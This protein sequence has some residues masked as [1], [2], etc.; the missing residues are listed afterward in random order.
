MVGSLLTHSRAGNVIKTILMDKIGD[1]KPSSTLEES[2]RIKKNKQ[3][4]NGRQIN[5]LI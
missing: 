5:I 2:K 1:G 3:T 4:K